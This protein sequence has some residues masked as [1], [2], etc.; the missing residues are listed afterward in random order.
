MMQSISWLKNVFSLILRID[1][2]FADHDLHIPTTKFKCE[3]GV[4]VKATNA[5]YTT[6]TASFWAEIEMQ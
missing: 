2:L 1:L 6:Q 3:L 5:P 4:D